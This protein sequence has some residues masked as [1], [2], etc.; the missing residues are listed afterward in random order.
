MLDSFGVLAITAV[1]LGV[2]HTL[3]G[4]DH[5]IP[6]VAMAEARQ[7]SIAKTML[8]TFLSGLGHI[9]SSVLIGFAGIMIG[10]SLQKLTLFETARGDIAAWLMIIFGL[11]YLIYGVK[12]AIKNKDHKHEHYHLDS[13][14][15]SHNHCH[16]AEH[17]HVHTEGKK[18]IS[19]WILFTLLVFGPCEPLI[20]VLIIPA[21]KNSVLDTVLI[22][23]LF[24][25]A[26]ILTM[27]GTVLVL[28]FGVKKIF[29][30]KLLRFNHAIAGGTI[31]MSG[32]AVKIFNL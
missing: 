12:K 13:K 29:S 21:L 5:Y 16:K 15:H 4:P 6:F 1:S 31:L 11:V 32:L 17:L 26:T 18:D 24:G 19:A 3:T 23:G 27:L 14:L 9:L 7:W 2:V 28:Y 20:P 8:I 10:K 30:A 25:A 22:T